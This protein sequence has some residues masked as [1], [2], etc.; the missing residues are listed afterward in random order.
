MGFPVLD[1]SYEKSKEKANPRSSSLSPRTGEGWGSNARFTLS[2]SLIKTQDGTVLLVWSNTLWI[3]VLFPFV[4][5]I[6][7][8]DNCFSLWEGEHFKT[9][10]LF[11]FFFLKKSWPNK[12]IIFPPFVQWTDSDSYSHRGHFCSQSAFSPGL[13]S[14]PLFASSWH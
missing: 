10:K 11:D 6:T 8:D 3:D 5:T 2:K 7:L 13:H 12:T 14:L 1:E 9:H 4:W